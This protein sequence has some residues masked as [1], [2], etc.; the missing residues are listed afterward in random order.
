MRFFKW[1]RMIL[2]GG[3]C[4]R[5]K[6]YH[7]THSLYDVGYCTRWATRVQMDIDRC[8]G[9]EE[10]ERKEIESKRVVHF[11]ENIQPILRKQDKGIF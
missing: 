2:Q 11:P 4:Y 8:A 10:L 6:H 5:C 3:R 1:I 7:K 9:F